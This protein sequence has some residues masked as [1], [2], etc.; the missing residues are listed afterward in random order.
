MLTMGIDGQLPIRYI[1][2]RYIPKGTA[3]DARELRGLEIAEAGLVVRK[4]GIRLVASQSGAGRYSVRLGAGN[5]YCTC[6]DHETHGGKC[7]HI[8]AV[9]HLARGTVAPSER[10]RLPRGVSKKSYP[11]DWSAYNAAQTHEKE[12]FLDLLRAICAAA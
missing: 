8:W 4:R 9:E 12:R 1:S 10:E 7:K 6:P 5:Y 2:S 11:Q 3:M